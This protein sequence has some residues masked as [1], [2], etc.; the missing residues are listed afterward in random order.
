VVV[1]NKHHAPAGGSGAGYRKSK[2]ISIMPTLRGK[3]AARERDSNAGQ[4]CA[5]QVEFG[6][7]YCVASAT[8]ATRQTPE[9]ISFPLKRG[10][11]FFREIK[12][13]KPRTF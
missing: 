6:L 11:G 7:Y 13:S 10:L 9:I 8:R 5:T 12:R 4:T 3:V 1:H 2:K